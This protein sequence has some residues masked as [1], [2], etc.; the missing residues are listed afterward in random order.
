MEGGYRDPSGEG[1]VMAQSTGQQPGGTP[2]LWVA[3]PQF[4]AASE[5]WLW[6]QTL[7]LSRF[8][9]VAVVTRERFAPDLYPLGSIPL[10]ILPEL[11]LVD[12]GAGRWFDRFVKVGTRNF[13]GMRRRQIRRVLERFDGSLPD[14]VLAHFGSTATKFAPLA[15]ALGVPLVAH[16]HALDVTSAL[17]NNRWYRWSL[18]AAHPHFAAAVVVGSH[19][20]TI[21]TDFGVPAEKVHLIPCG[22]PVADF[23]TVTRRS[24]PGRTQFITVSRLA[25][26]KGLTYTLAAFA[27]VVRGGDD[28]S[29]TIVGDGPM[30]AE[31]ERF[32]AELGVAQRVIFT[33]VAGP[34]EVRHLLA[35]SDVFLQHSVEYL[36]ET[37]GFGV[38]I[39]EASA[40]GLPVVVSDCGGIPDQVLDGKTGFIVPQRDVAAMA[41]RMRRLTRDLDLR[42]R[43]GEQARDHVTAHFDTPDLV[44]RL[45]DVLEASLGRR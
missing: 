40:S 27:N 22:V 10:A 16:F 37:E 19:Q 43:L 38:S 29:L 41:E 14:V 42:Q 21:L 36:N 33:G 5:T 25:P 45:K 3:A 9:D 8:F 2:R 31:L 6:R 35:A 12:R 34:A 32:S 17:R 20:K 7:G 44:E 13:Y 4:G 15:D 39:T 1:G 18:R 30:R 28:V 26:S 24:V 23:V 11:T